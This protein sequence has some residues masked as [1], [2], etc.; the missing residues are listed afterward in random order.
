MI[1]YDNSGTSTTTSG[2][3][4]TA[5]FTNAGNYLIVDTGVNTTACSY[6][7]VAMSVIATWTSSSNPPS[8]KVWG[9]ANPAIGTYT[10]LATNGAGFNMSYVSLKNVDTSIS[11]P[12]NYTTNNTGGST[13]SMLTQ[14]ITP[15][16]DSSW[17]VGGARQ[18]NGFN[19]NWSVSG[20]GTLRQAGVASG[21]LACGIADLTTPQD[22]TSHTLQ[23]LLSGSGYL[24]GW[25]AAFSPKP[26]DLVGQ[27][28]II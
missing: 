9:L 22:T 4:L 23:L 28:I 6:N 27:M 21:Y 5:S 7:G 2:S 10:I 12:T 13:S 24:S 8:V 14:T 16:K 17:V 15:V 19:N 20:A 18:V 3:D 26:D 1:T 11:Q 25:L